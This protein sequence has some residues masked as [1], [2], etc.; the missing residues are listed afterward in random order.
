MNEQIY[1]QTELTAELIGDE[2]IPIEKETSPGVWETYYIESDKLIST[3]LKLTGK[4]ANFTQVIPANA[5]LESINLLGSGTFKV[6]K[7]LGADDVIY[8]EIVSNLS[9]NN[10][11]MFF[12]KASTQTLYFTISSGS[13]D[14]TIIYTSSIF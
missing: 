7:T 11:G 6:G 14:I 5:R 8:E 1:Q 10:L 13:F 3:K 9:I 12:S 4:S 2:R